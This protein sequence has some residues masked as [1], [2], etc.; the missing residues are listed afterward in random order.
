M[1]YNRNEWN[2]KLSYWSSF[3]DRILIWIAVNGDGTSD[4]KSTIDAWELFMLDVYESGGV[5]GAEVNG[6]FG[7]VEGKNSTE[8]SFTLLS[9]LVMM[10]LNESTPAGLKVTVIW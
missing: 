1:Q 7:L 8:N 4:E 6:W 2:V 10:L 3:V 9:A 5:P